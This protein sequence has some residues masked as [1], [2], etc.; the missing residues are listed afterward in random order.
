MTHQAAPRR[1][2]I[3]WRV[4]IAVFALILIAAL[5]LANALDLSDKIT[6]AT[7]TVLYWGAV[8]WHR[9]RRAH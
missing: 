5:A 1:Q 7:V 8:L 6:L 3:R 9:S 4:W 2:Q